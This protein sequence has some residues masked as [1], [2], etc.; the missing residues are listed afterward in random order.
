MYQDTL[1]PTKRIT[2]GEKT[3][4]NKWLIVFSGLVAALLIVGAVGA[5]A[6]YALEPSNLLQ[7]GRGP[8]WHGFRFSDAELEAVARVLGMTADEVSSALQAGK[9]LQDLANE[10]GVDIADVQAALQAVRVAE[11]RDAIAQAVANGTMTQ[12]KANWLL[13]GLDKGFIGGGF[14]F[15]RGFGMYGRGFGN[16]FGNC[17]MVPTPSASGQ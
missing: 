4:K 3:M 2:Q 7:H 8:G 12:E 13:E 10:K 9:T 14:G 6:V 11:M 16:G 1:V 17:P 15:G 5:T